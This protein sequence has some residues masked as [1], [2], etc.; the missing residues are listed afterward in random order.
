[1]KIVVLDGHALNPGDLD[2]APLRTLGDAS[3]FPRTAPAEIMSRAIG[4]EILLTNKTPLDAACIAACPALRYIGVLAT[5]HNVVDGAAARRRGIPVT[6]VPG[7][8][9][10]AVA[11][12]VF[13]LL[14][15]LTNRVGQHAAGVRSGRWTEAPDW[16]YTEAPLQELAGLTLGIIG[17]GRIGEAV[18]GIGRALGMVVT[19]VG[20]GAG[21]T[22]LERVLRGSDVISLHCPL[23][24]E[25]RH[26]IN[27]TTLGWMKPGALL[28]NT[29][30]GPL[31]DEPALA[32][33]LRSGHLAGAG[34]DVLSQEPPPAGHPLLSA[35]NCL[36]T[37]HNAWAARAARQRLLTAAMANLRAFLAGRAENVVN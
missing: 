14:L 3:V 6:N 22:G 35:P 26:L 13:A 37:P 18:A 20:R 32:D 16:C 28:I 1:M 7:Y 11:Q 25:T 9:T 29:A 36:I 4:A 34:L 12:H 31:I 8:G 2:W 30:R 10:Q 23:T 5:G 15:E 17:A 19:V 27:A 21:R 24:E 33:A